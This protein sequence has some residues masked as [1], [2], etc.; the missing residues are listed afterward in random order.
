MTP[1]ELPIVEIDEAAVRSRYAA[2][3]RAV[4]PALCCP[5]QYDARYLELV[6]A[7]IIE[8]DYGCGDPTPYVRPGD[9]VLDLGSGGG[10]ACYIAAQIVG[11]QGRVIGVD[12]NQEMLSLARG[13]LASF[14]E[15]LGCANLEF[16]CGL[17]QDLR[18]DLERLADQWGER[19]MTDASGWLELRALEE[20]LRR[21]QPLVSDESVDCVIS[22]CVL[23]LVRPQD[24]WQL[25]DEVF[26]V[27]KPGGRAAISDIVA[28]RDVPENLQR[29]ADLWSGCISGAFREDQFL[30]AFER[31]GFHGIQLVKRQR[32]PWRTVE[33]IQFRSATVLAY[34]G[35]QAPCTE[36]TGAVIYR[37]PFRQVEDDDGHLFARG[38]RTPVCGKTLQS[39][40]REPYA[41]LF[42]AIA[43]EEAEHS[44]GAAPGDGSPR[45]AGRRGC[46]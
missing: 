30:A 43:S 10:K 46:C 9:V 38:Q 7:E 15:R 27:L 4:E 13:S 23:N 16:R 39:L 19:P 1:A 29:D 20:R 44:D 34:K 11:P 6:P 35:T 37:G 33:G 28:D 14:A 21:E 5:V 42:E 25:F 12:C 18:L 36:P 32:E 2:A 31:A 22:N 45:D 8:R 24:R 17:I 40:Q 41:G 26:R 3:A